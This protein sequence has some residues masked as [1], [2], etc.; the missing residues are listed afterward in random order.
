M[1][2]KILRLVATGVQDAVETA[3]GLLCS[4]RWAQTAASAQGK[5]AVYPH[6]ASANASHPSAL[7]IA[8]YVQTDTLHRGGPVPAM[9]ALRCPILLCR[10][11]RP[12][13]TCVPDSSLRL[14]HFPK[15]FRP[16]ARIYHP[17]WCKYQPSA[18]KFTVKYQFE[19]I[20]SKIEK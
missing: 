6:K 15:F 20:S 2:S 8:A 1:I 10:I 5:D 4:V 11:E 16:A 3:H 18:L 7:T 14:N 9:C 13:S 12:V 17:G 19:Q